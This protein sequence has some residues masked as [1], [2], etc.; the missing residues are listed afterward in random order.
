MVDLA[1]K[2][3]YPL[4]LESLQKGLPEAQ[5]EVL[6]TVDMTEEYCCWY[7]TLLDNLSSRTESLKER[8]SEADIQKV[9]R[10]FESLLSQLKSD[11]LRGAAVY[12]RKR[13]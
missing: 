7:K 1:G 13:P 11:T 8:F 10:T 9:S 4:H 6:E 12:A 2:P 3:M 5:W